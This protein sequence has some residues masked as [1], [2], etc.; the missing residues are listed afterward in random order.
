M[1]RLF[2]DISTP[3]V[4]PRGAIPGGGMRATVALIVLD[5]RQGATLLRLHAPKYQLDKEC[6]QGGKSLSHIAARHDAAALDDKDGFQDISAERHSQKIGYVGCRSSHSK[7]F[8]TTKH[9]SLLTF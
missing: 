5:A 2:N 7:S 4:G 8:A 3:V 6:Y 9:L 1:W